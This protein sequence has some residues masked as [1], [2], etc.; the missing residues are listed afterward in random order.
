MTGTPVDIGTAHM[1]IRAW[2]EEGLRAVDP[3]AA[4]ARAISWDG[5][6][7]NVGDR[8]I[9]VASQS[10]VVAIAIGKAATGMAWGLDSVAGHQLDSRVILTKDGH[11]TN[12]PD[13][14]EVFE[15]RHPIPDE[16]GVAATRRIL[17][18][19]SGMEAGDVAIVLIS[20]G[21]SA[22]LEAP[23][24]P[25][26]LAE[27]QVL[28]DLLLRAGAPIQDLNA[29]RSELS[30]VKGGGLRRA[31]GQATCVSLILS[32]VLGSDPR[33]I[34]SGPT[35]ARDSRPDLALALIDRYGVRAHVPE[36]VIALL[37]VTRPEP[38]RPESGDLYRIIG[39][40]RLFLSRIEDMA[41]S[42]GFTPKVV[43]RD[44]EGEARELANRFIDFLLAQPP[45]V[46]V[47]IGGGEA[48]VTLRG[49]GRGG[50]NTEF[51]LAAAMRLEAEDRDWVIASLASDGQ[52]GMVDAA[53]AIVDRGT[54]GRGRAFG[55]DADSSLANNDSGTYFEVVGGLVTPGPT[56]T[57][58]NDAYV[59]IRVGASPR[60][61]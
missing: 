43:L 58:V 21:G 4:V 12:P 42:S 18:I 53:G 32:D 28:T 34:A 11:A 44:A 35:I 29:V 48:T 10:R 51:A 27:I 45:D 7:L 37:E 13:G 8:S 60:G 22:L 41:R 38:G 57:N 56:G 54:L 52:D 2:Y 36:A 19:V 59:G 5:E 20:G 30:E 17:E 25:L 3:R 49:D 50:R 39:D 14:W 9:G 40:N 1:L 61:R 55:L 23:R 46:D 47:A 16:R 24:L 6:R 26:G 15:A 33:L 31:I